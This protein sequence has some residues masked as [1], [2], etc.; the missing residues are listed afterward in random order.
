MYLDE[1]CASAFGCGCGYM[2]GRSDEKADVL[3]LCGVQVVVQGFELQ[4]R[5]DIVRCRQQLRTGH[6]NSVHVLDDTTIVPQSCGD[7]RTDINFV[8]RYRLWE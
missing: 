6:T 8:D 1:A 7:V 4:T 5:G 2:R 3:T